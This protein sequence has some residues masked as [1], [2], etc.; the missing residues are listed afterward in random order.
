[1]LSTHEQILGGPHGLSY[2]GCLTARRARVRGRISDDAL[3]IGRFL[4]GAGRDRAVRRSTSSPPAPVTPGRPYALE[5]NLRNGGTTHPFL[6][7]QALT[8]GLYDTPRSTFTADGKAKFYVAT[9]HLENPAYAR[10]TTD[11]FLDLL[12][13]HDLAWDHERLT[14]AV[15]HLASAIG[16]MGI[17]GLTA[18][19]DTRE[20]AQAT[21]DRAR[22]ALDAEAAMLAGP[23]VSLERSSPS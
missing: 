9:D 6:T 15:F 19:G 18:I 3:A 13:R 14:G 16:G 2:Q 7:L 5:I 10:L 17:V 20:G 22:A 4:A 12:P 1:M 21:F 8:N 11:D 23:D